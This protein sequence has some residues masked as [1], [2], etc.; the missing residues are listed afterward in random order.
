MSILP[1]PSGNQL[2]HHS[3]M[4]RI[5]FS[6]TVFCDFVD[7]CSGCPYLGEAT[8]SIYSEIDGAVTLLRYRMD[9]VGCCNV[10]CHPHYGSQGYPATLFTTAD[11]AVVL[12]CIRELADLPRE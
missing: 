1:I 11:A 7:P 2:D 4:A 8:S 12:A 10:V 5:S 9:N 3:L 6:S